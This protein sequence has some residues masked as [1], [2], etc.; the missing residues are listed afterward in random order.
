MSIEHGNGTYFAPDEPVSGGISSGQPSNDIEGSGEHDTITEEEARKQIEFIKFHNGE[1]CVE[2]SE[3]EN[4]DGFIIGVLLYKIANTR[5]SIEY[6]SSI[7][8]MEELVENSKK[9][10][11][12]IWQNMD[13]WLRLAKREPLLSSYARTNKDA[14]HNFSHYAGSFVNMFKKYGE[15]DKTEEST[16]DSIDGGFESE[17]SRMKK[18][19]MDRADS[20]ERKEKVNQNFLRRRELAQEDLD[21]IKVLLSE[22]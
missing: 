4:Y 17:L 21:K 1:E 20:D 22:K 13:I 8:G 6:N 19:S 11:D 3:D 14:R 10:I 16:N 12:R 7:I 2:L 9:D 5:Q 18:Q 15:Q